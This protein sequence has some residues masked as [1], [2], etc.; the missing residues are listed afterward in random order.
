MESDHSLL[1]TN[2]SDRDYPGV[3]LRPGYRIAG[4]V[5]L[6]VKR[7]KL[8]PRP[9]GEVSGRPVRDR[10]EFGAIAERRGCFY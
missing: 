7:S 9:P 8:S 5:K 4:V 1:W 10:V 3:L 6:V 2:D